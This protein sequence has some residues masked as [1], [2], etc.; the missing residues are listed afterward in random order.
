MKTSKKI[1]KQKMNERNKKKRKTKNE[2]NKTLIF[3]LIKKS[4]F[5]NFFY[6]VIFT[7]TFMFNLNELML[8]TFFIVMYKIFNILNMIDL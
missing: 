2:M 3:Y 6:F 1:K 7:L 8:R 5:S 4:I